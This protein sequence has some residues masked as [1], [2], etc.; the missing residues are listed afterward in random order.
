MVK[1]RSSRSDILSTLPFVSLMVNLT[2]LRMVGV[3]SHGDARLQVRQVEVGLPVPSIR[4]AEQGKERLVLVDRQELAIGLRPARGCERKRKNP[5][6]AEIWV[7][8]GFSP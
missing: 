2:T 7:C 4:G 3:E 5:D 6:F 1:P 8:H